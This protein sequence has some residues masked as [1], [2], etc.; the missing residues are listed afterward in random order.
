MISEDME[1]ALVD[2]FYFM[3]EIYE[4]NQT[5]TLSKEERS[6]VKEKLSEVR[7]YASDSDTDQE[8]MAALERALNQDQPSSIIAIAE[9]HINL[10]RSLEYYQDKMQPAFLP[11]LRRRVQILS[12]AEE[13]LDDKGE[14]IK[15]A[16]SKCASIVLSCERSLKE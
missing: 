7:A 15:E 6:R 11:E 4:G 12:R 8:A 16:E 2:L 5:G 14:L 10:K 3:H 13:L 9:R 1:W